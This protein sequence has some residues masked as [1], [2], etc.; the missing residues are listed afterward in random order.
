MTSGVHE[1][2][3]LT[4]R[5]RTWAFAIVVIAFVMDLL[6]VTIVNVALPAVGQALHAGTAQVAW[7]VAA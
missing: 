3:P 4:G 2:P 1:P 6:D 7:I 5:R